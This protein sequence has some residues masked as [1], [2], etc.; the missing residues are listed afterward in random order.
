ML[1]GNFGTAN[2]LLFGDGQ[3]GFTAAALSSAAT[4]TT[5]RTN[6]VALGDLNVR[7][8][9]RTNSVEGLVPQILAL[10]HSKLALTRIHV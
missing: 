8:P 5:A 10:C 3:G 2:E 4:N 7:A 6:A 1:V 9:N